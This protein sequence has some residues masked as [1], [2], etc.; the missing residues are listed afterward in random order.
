M[1]YSLGEDSPASSVPSKATDCHHHIFD[2]RYPTAPDAVLRPNDALIS[3]YREL[4]RRIGTSRNVIIQ[5]STYGVDNRLLVESLGIFG[6]DTAR[7]VAVVNSSVA[8]VELRALHGAG[9]RG[10]RF[11]LAPPGATTLAMV[12]P[13]AT[14]IA[15]MGWH[16]QINAPAEVLWATK[17]LWDN[18]PV[19][20]VF[21]H[22]GRVPQPGAIDHPT[23]AMI[24]ELVQRGK[25]Y[26]KLSG[27]YNES[28]TGPP[29]YADSVR[30]ASI[31]ANDAPERM[32]WGSDWPH[33]TEEAKG[34]P[35]DA[36]LL[37][38]LSTVVPNETIR[39]G[40]LVDN[41]A[42]LYEFD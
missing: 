16:I 15:S 23:F 18:L 39:N 2:S 40:I 37:D 14:R 8:D 36:N 1:K 4:Q 21:D 9:V 5:P 19:P 35:D 17:S 38:L 30:V 33:P 31:Y 28:R 26:V 11:N 13:L 32:L 25:G 10:I 27:F 12:R 3:D 34:Y 42:K 24:R 22:L 6:M 7:G 29:T 20:I 41:P